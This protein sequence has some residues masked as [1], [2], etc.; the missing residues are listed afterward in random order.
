MSTPDIPASSAKISLIDVSGKEH[1]SKE[2]NT[3]VKIGKSGVV[4][5][6]A[7]LIETIWTTGTDEEKFGNICDNL[8]KLLPHLV[9]VEAVDKV[10]ASTTSVTTLFTPGATLTG[11]GRRKS[12]RNHGR[13]RG[14]RTRSR[15]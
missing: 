1:I 5:K 2:L 14:R 9:K 3:N 15:R 12:R 10:A 13:K 8:V 7:T 4:D 6:L 11:G